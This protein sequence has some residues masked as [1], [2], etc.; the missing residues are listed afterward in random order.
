[1]E[2]DGERSGRVQDCSIVPARNDVVDFL[3][4]GCRIGA[5]LS[6][7]RDDQP[8]AECHADRKYQPV[9]PP[10][11]GTKEGQGENECAI[12]PIGDARLA[13]HHDAIVSA[14]AG[15]IVG[16]GATP[17]DASSPDARIRISFTGREIDIT[18]R[19][20]APRAAFLLRGKRTPRIYGVNVTIQS[21][22]QNQHETHR[23]LSA[24][25]ARPVSIPADRLAW[26]R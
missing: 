3:G 14:A 9:F 8:H 15:T 5:C 26:Q 18:P 12:R 22:V 23:R 20:L 16:E 6:R 7:E 17:P 2:S 10:V 21:E 11:V 25:F 1:M 13:L 4:G 19:L 24:K